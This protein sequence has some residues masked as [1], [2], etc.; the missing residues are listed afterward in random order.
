MALIQNIR[1]V[2]KKRFLEPSEQNSYLQGHA[3]LLL[4]SFKHWTGRALINDTLPWV[5][6]AQKLFNAPFAVASHD[7]ADDPIL[8]YGNKTAM[9]LWEVVWIDFTSLPSRKTAESVAQEERK[10]LLAEVTAHGFID[11]YKGIRVSATGRRF[12]IERA[13]VWNLINEV[14]EFSGQAAMFS[15]WRFL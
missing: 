15:E 14:G 9:R 8:N 11:H 1:A 2:G 5:E 3:T 7:T 6:Q 12:M 4:R 13:T 10:R